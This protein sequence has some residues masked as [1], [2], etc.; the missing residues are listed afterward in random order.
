MYEFLMLAASLA[1]GA[2]PQQD[3]KL[4]EDAMD[5]KYR[6]EL[7]TLRARSAPVA[8]W[9]NGHKVLFKGKIVGKQVGAAQRDGKQYTTLLVRTKEGGTAMVELGPAKYV[10]A[11]GFRFDLGTELWVAGSK[12]WVNNDSLILAERLNV[13]GF[14]PAFRRSDGRPFWR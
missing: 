4:V 14:R 8:E 10:E 1:T 5:L 2:M 7:A 9:N 11:Q 6:N 3:R 12:T 13:G